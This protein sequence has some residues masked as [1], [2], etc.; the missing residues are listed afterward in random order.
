MGLS[1]R[2]FARVPLPHLLDLFQ[3]LNEVVARRVLQRR[4]LNVGLEFL[5]PQL[6]ANGQHVRIIQR[7]TDG[8]ATMD[9]A[10]IVDWFAQESMNAAEQ[11]NE[12]KR[13]AS[14]GRGSQSGE[15]LSTCSRFKSR[16]G[17]HPKSRGCRRGGAGY[18]GH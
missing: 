5:Q 3:D 1:S 11:T 7:K 18:P 15:R 6:L 2:S 4:E 9:F 13:R 8:T 14:L 12:P 16:R 17:N 10:S